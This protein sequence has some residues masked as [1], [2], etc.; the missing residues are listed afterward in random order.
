[1]KITNQ[2]KKSL[3]KSLLSV[4]AITALTLPGMAFAQDVLPAS[5]QQRAYTS[6][7]W[8]TP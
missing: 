5:V 7:I 3:C 4:V 8:Y 2:E 1:M 6:P